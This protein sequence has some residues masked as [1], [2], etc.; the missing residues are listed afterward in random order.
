M[1]IILF[2]ILTFHFSVYTF[3][4]EYF[5]EFVPGWRNLKISEKNNFYLSFGLGD[6]ISSSSSSNLYSFSEISFN[7]DIDSTW[8]FLVDTAFSTS[9]RLV[10]T[11]YSSDKYNYICGAIRGEQSFNIYGTLIRFENNFQDTILTKVYDLGVDTRMEIILPVENNQ[12]IVGGLLSVE[13]Y[14]NN[15]AMYS[16]DTLGNI[17][18]SQ[19]YACGDNCDL[20]P[21][22][23]LKASDEGYFYTI[24]KYFSLGQPEYTEKTTIIKTDSLGNEQYRLHPGNPDLFTVSGWVLP[25]DDGN[26]ITAYSDPMT[27]T[28]SLPQG[29][30]ESTIWINKF[31][32]EGNEI[33][34]NSLWDYLPKIEPVQI[35]YRYTITQMLITADNNILIVGYK[36]GVK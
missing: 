3:A 7:S 30:N 34:E 36:I 25:T 17:I 16:L 27:I 5:F 14:V 21:Y 13:Q 9:T 1:R 32:I 33:F 4:Q 28:N 19:M 6:Y 35:G 18:W 31:D 10:N 8:D 26:Y 22:H 15:S 20:I 24:K 2:L 12:M 23:I 11:I 29:N